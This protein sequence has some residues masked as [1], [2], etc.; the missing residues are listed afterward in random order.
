[1]FKRERYDTVEDVFP[2]LYERYPLGREE[3]E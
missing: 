1:M 2:V 3:E